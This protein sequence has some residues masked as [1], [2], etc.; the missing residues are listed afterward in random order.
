MVSEN[1][2]GEVLGIL[3]DTV[4]DTQVNNFFQFAH[5]LACVSVY[6]NTKKHK[7][8]NRVLYIHDQQLIN[9]DELYH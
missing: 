3:L 9:K 6:A 2:D 4:I 8:R 5:R 1:M 7:S